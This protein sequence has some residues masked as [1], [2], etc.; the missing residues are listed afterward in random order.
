[1]T[2]PSSVGSARFLHISWPASPDLLRQ[3]PTTFINGL[4]STEAHV[5]CGTP[6]R[7]SRSRSGPSCATAT[8]TGSSTPAPAA[9]TWRSEKL[10]QGSYIPDRLG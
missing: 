4:M 6:G 1:M 5:I 10:R 9:W 2:A 7:A 8:G 3:M